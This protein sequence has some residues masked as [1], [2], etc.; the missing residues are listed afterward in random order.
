MRTLDVKHKLMDSRKPRLL[1][2]ESTHRS[3]S[4][5][6]A[7]VKQAST[8]HLLSRHQHHKASPSPA[9]QRA[10]I[11]A[12]SN[13]PD[14]INGGELSRSRAEMMSYETYPPAA[15]RLCANASVAYENGQAISTTSG[16]PLADTQLKVTVSDAKKFFRTNGFKR[17][18]A[19]RSIPG[20]IVAPVVGRSSAQSPAEI[21]FCPATTP[22]KESLSV[23]TTSNLKRKRVDSSPP[24]LSS[25]S[26]S[27]HSGP[28][29]DTQLDTLH[30][31]CLAC[32]SEEFCAPSNHSQS[33]SSA[34]RLEPCCFRCQKSSRK[35]GPSI[36]C[37]Y[38]PLTYHLGCLTPPM[39]SLPS[40]TSA[41]MCPN[42]VEPTV[43]RSVLKRRIPCP[44]QRVKIYHRP[45]PIESSIVL[46]EF[47][48]RQQ[49]TDYLPSSNLQS[50]QIP[51]DIEELYSRAHRSRA[52]RNIDAD[53]QP[54]QT[55]E[56]IQVGIDSLPVLCYLSV[57]VHSRPLYPRLRMIHVYGTHCKTFST[58]SST[59]NRIQSRPSTMFCRRLPSNSQLR[60]NRRR[61]RASIRYST[62]C[63]RQTRLRHSPLLLIAANEL[64]Y[65]KSSVFDATR[66]DSPLRF[67]QGYR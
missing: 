52:Q 40:S 46:Q 59:V 41:W 37:D 6:T 10:D 66:S 60:K 14:A 11:S 15:D 28:M 39:A 17:S 13:K 29:S 30:R 58:I 57:R 19:A 8:R 26:V 32:P 35:H 45:S 27:P 7:K 38:C 64:N 12:A 50:S 36:H 62:P 22:K 18:Q 53:D 49:T 25:S 65:R 5:P 24:T 20:Q 4:Q 34:V 31:L 9:H 33:N 48:Q 16:E 44:S 3:I 2:N 1:H 21:K 47:S 43:D 51:K 63:M 56:S 23:T 61:W 67:F 42:H 54:E 55:M